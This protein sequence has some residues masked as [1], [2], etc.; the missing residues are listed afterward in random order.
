MQKHRREGKE[1]FTIGIGINTG[2]V[3][4]GNIGC[5]NRM[6]FTVIGDP[7]NVAA[8]LQA[9]AKGGQVI[10]GEATRACLDTGIRVKSCGEV[11]LRNKSQP[12]NCYQV[13]GIQA[14]RPE[15]PD[16]VPATSDTAVM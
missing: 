9:L 15:N 13:T 16:R 1:V 3:I 6:D 7:V 2:E 4:L 8:R 11:R 5:E 10:I 14:D 12:V